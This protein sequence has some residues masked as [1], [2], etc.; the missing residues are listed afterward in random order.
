MTDNAQK[1]LAWRKAQKLSRA[2]LAEL[3]GFSASQI[4]DYE[5]GERRGKADARAVISDAAWKRY[6]M[7]CAAV[8]AELSKPW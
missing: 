4:Q 3:I 8:A 6:W 7:A 1:A 5:E 2:K